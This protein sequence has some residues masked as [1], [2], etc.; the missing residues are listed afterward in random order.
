MKSKLA[1]ILGASLLAGSAFAQTNQVLSRNA[2]GYVKINL[3]ASNKLHLVA[4]TFEP[5]G[6]PIAISN[7]L[8]ELPP[9]SS[10]YLWDNGAQQYLPSIGKTA[11]G[12]GP[13]A[14]N[15]LTRGRAFFIR[16]PSTATNVASFPIHLMGEVPDQI[17]AP[18]TTTAV[19]VGLGLTA[20]TYPVATSWTN[21]ALAKS[22]PIFSSIYVWD[23]SA[24]AYLPSMGKTVFGWSPAAKALVLQP[25]Q[26]IIVQSTGTV[27]AVEVKPY[28]WP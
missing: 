13:G 24:Q 17:T 21:T 11:F 10:V 7:A 20:Y 22:L 25:G 14:S 18:T 5:L 6:A 8:N 27:S 12:W 2:V 16:T 15:K 9:F 19:A 28:T 4:N 23:V 3:I 26:G 1:V